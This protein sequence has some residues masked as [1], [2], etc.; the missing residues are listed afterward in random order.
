MTADQL[1]VDVIEQLADAAPKIAHGVRRGLL[2][3]DIADDLGPA[4][5]ALIE[6]AA[7]LFFPGAGT[8]IELITFVAEHAQAMTQDETNKWMDRQGIANQS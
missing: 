6:Y 8:A 4:T 2:P 3:E 5:L 1:P 7:N